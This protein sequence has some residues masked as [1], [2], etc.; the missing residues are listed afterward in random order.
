MHKLRLEKIQ[1]FAE[2]FNFSDENNKELTDEQMRKVVWF[3]N[4][5]TAPEWRVTF[6]VNAY[7]LF[8]FKEIGEKNVNRV[9]ELSP[10][11]Y[12][13][14]VKARKQVKDHKEVPE[15]TKEDEKK[16]KKK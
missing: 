11:S 2:K 1:G 9:K 4:Q 7:R 12:A 15:V 14:A 3:M 8:G 13:W 16:T 10:E 5:L 6:V